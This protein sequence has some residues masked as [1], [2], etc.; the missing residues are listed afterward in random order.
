MASEIEARGS[1]TFY[2]SGGG[3]GLDFGFTSNMTGAKS[4][5]VKQSIPTT[6]EALQ[7]GEVAAGGLCIIK[8][9]DGTNFVAIKAA[10][11][12]TPLIR[13]NAGESAAFRLHGSASAPVAQADTAA[14]VIQFILLEA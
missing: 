2:K 3:D 1:L 6:E 9:L 5:K 14:V 13:I 10:A 8:N 12:A 11:G 4:T 7:L